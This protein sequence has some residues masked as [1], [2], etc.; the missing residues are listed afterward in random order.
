MMR[1]RMKNFKT[2]CSQVC[3]KG[4]FSG[5][6]AACEWEH[7]KHMLDA[8]VVNMLF[9]IVFFCDLSVNAA[10][11]E[12]EHHNNVYTTGEHQRTRRRRNRKNSET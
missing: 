6:I 12:W 1:R 11:V 2:W 7:Q 4:W 5:N 10:V 8:Q 3:F 9:S